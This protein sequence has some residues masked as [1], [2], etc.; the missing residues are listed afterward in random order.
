MTSMGSSA[1]ESRMTPDGVEPAET[2]AG[3]DRLPVAENGGCGWEGNG[4]VS[5]DAHDRP[6]P[7]RDPTRRARRLL[8]ARNAAA[9]RGAR[10]S[11]AS[12]GAAVMVVLAL[13]FV[14]VFGPWVGSSLATASLIYRPGFAAPGRGGSLV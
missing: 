7:R 5:D 12:T 8:T 4:H 2:R 11:L 1:G 14:G 6:G 9:L 10:G 3:R 13:T